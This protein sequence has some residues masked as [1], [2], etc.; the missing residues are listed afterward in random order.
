MDDINFSSIVEC[1]LRQGAEDPSPNMFAAISYIVRCLAADDAFRVAFAD[2]DR[3]GSLLEILR[4][5]VTQGMYVPVADL[6]AG[7][8]HFSKV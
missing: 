1:I 2:Q 7:F 5:C 8:T 3:L 4:Q 6:M